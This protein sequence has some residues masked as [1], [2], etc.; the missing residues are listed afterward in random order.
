MARAN[1]KCMQVVIWVHHMQIDELFD[2]LNERIKNAP[3][4]WYDQSQ[5]PYSV[6][7]GY[8]QVVLPY[9]SYS[10]LRSARDWSDQDWYGPVS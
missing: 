9:E 4:Y 8:V 6:S 10:N 2:F 5:L 3:P 1:M 7:G